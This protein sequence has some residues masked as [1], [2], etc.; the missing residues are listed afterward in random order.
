VE[1]VIRYFGI[2]KHVDTVV[3]WFGGVKHGDG[4]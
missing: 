1:M 2:V 4:D 3:R